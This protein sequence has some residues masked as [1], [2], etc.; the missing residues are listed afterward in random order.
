M[1]RPV[2]SAAERAQYRLRGAMTAWGTNDLPS[3]VISQGTGDTALQ[4]V[5]ALGRG[6]ECGGNRGPHPWRGQRNRQAADR[7]RAPAR[8]GAE[9]DYTA[10]QR[11]ASL[12]RTAVDRPGAAGA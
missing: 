5:V 11:P 10:E 1:G 7:A 2:G 3:C 9:A 12:R 8:R 6:D 4:G